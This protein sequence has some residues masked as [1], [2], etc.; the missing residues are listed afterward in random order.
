MHNSGGGVPQGLP[1]ST[2]TVETL[3][4]ERVMEMTSSG[5]MVPVPS[6]MPTAAKASKPV[7]LVLAGLQSR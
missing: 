2:G 1:I 7:P 5:P 3:V 4:W 6:Q